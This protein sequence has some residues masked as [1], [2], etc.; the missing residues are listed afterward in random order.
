MVM[1]VQKLIV[2]CGFTKSNVGD[3]LESLVWTHQTIHLCLVQ[4]VYRG[5]FCIQRW[6]QGADLFLTQ[7]WT[8]CS[9]L[10][11]N[12]YTL[13]QCLN[14]SLN[15]EL[16]F[17]M[18]LNLL[19]CK[20]YPEF[21]TRLVNYNFDMC[22][23]TIGVGTELRL[24]LNWDLGVLVY[25]LQ[26]SLL[27]IVYLFQNKFLIYNHYV[28]SFKPYTV[29]TENRDPDLLHTAQVLRELWLCSCQRTH[30]PTVWMLCPYQ[31]ELHIIT[32]GWGA[33]GY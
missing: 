12:K 17:E 28:C 22:R 9:C 18:L 21:G 15:W 26:I 13:P 24:S 30:E 31:Q 27:C 10:H 23:I 11:T 7:L 29:T 25:A 16:T 1:Q 8:E 33:A 2:C 3:L 5:L 4:A 20:C 6:V 14:I 32:V 19:S